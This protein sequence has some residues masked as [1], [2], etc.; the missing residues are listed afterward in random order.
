MAAALDTILSGFDQLFA[1]GVTPVDER[2]AIGCARVFEQVRRRADAACVALVGAI[3][4]DGLVR[5]DGHG[6]AATMGRH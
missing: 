4:R 3:E 6:S 5:E 2:D 1:A